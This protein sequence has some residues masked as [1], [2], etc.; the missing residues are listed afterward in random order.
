MSYS[1]EVDMK[2]NAEANT[3]SQTL[4][5]HLHAGPLAIAN[6]D[7]DH[8]KELNDQYGYAVGDKVLEAFHNALTNSL[9][10]NAHVHRPGG[11]EWIVILPGATPEDALIL[12]EEIRRHF[13]SRPP[14]KEVNR[15]ASATIGIAASPVHA[16][17]PDQL[18]RASAEARHQAKTTGGD[19]T[20]I[21]QEQR[22]VMKSNYYTQGQLARLNTLSERL[23]RTEAS[24]LREALDDLQHKYA[25]L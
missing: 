16:T 8:F 11:D 18:L 25:H 22:M 1:R 21:Y 23:Q 9:P 20:T 14:T 19:R 2:T 24:L 7:L 4:S 15:P 13:G 3:L 5:R 17:D 6:I 12:M 10:T